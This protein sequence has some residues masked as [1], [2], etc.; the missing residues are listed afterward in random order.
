[1]GRVMGANRR[2]SELGPGQQAA[3]M[4]VGSME[5][6]LTLTALVD[7]IRRTGSP[8]RAGLTRTAP[9]HDCDPKDPHA[10]VHRASCLMSAAVLRGRRWPGCV[11]PDR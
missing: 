6:A 8:P 2:W 4:I 5:L 11:W 10:R 7:L 1:M 9:A 3:A